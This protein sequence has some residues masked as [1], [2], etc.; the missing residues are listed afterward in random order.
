M[1]KKI[2]S[3]LTNNQSMRLIPLF[4]IIFGANIVPMEPIKTKKLA[5]QSAAQR[6]RTSSFSKATKDKHDYNV[7]ESSE[8]ECY[9][10]DGT[11]SSYENINPLAYLFEKIEPFNLAEYPSKSGSV[12]P[13]YTHNKKTYVILTREAHGKDKR[14]Y[15]DFSGGR[16]KKDKHPRIASAREFYEEAILEKTLGWNLE[17]TIQFLNPKNSH[18][19]AII[20]Y[21]KDKNPQRPNSRD[22]KNVT[23]IVDFNKYAK[24]LFNNF[25]TALS[26]E[27][28]KKNRS[29]TEKDRI[30]GVLL[31]DLKEAIIN[32]KDRRS[33]F[34]SANVL[35][36]RTNSFTKE[37]ITLRP[38]LVEKLFPDFLNMPYEE[39][40]NKKTKHYRVN[41]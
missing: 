33:V 1:L 10:A 24:P 3:I 11:E 5:A 40:E 36:P 31:E 7:T 20:A 23:Y 8:E 19:Q 15:D 18:T 34:V 39:G 4:T 13:L 28:A 37:Q 26:E 27:K 9:L 22:V 2:Q 32:K 16:E 12:L 41:R 6:I 38:F 25:Y 21:S 30:A 17:D 29:T 35:N 14:K